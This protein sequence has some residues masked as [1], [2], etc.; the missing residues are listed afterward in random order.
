M[1]PEH[2]KLVQESFALFRPDLGLFAELLY[3][4]LFEQCPKIQYMYRGD[5]KEQERKLAGML[6]MI[7]NA[8][9]QVDNIKPALWNLGRRHV[10]YGVRAKDYQAFGEVLMWTLEKFL[11]TTFTPEVEDSW[12]AFYEH[13]SGIMRGRIDY[14]IDREAKPHTTV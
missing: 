2:V 9:D 8:L 11:Y 7:V 13:I 14:H 5:R 1:T 3:M 10:T 12:R 6:D 4:E